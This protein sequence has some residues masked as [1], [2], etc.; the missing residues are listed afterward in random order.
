[1]KNTPILLLKAEKS[2]KMGLEE[3]ERLRNEE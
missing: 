2:T 3:L 1:M